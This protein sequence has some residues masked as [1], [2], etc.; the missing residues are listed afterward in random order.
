V[1]TADPARTLL[2]LV[3][4]L[5]IDPDLLLATKQIKFR[6]STAVVHYALDRL[7]EVPGLTQPEQALASVVSLTPALDDLE[8]A[9]DA[10]KYGE[11]SEEPHIEISVPTLR[12]PSLAPSGKHVLSA[13]VRYAPHKLR[14]GATWDGTAS[15]SLA[16]RVTSTI[17]EA[18]P[19][20]VQSVRQR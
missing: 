11:V 5:W 18:I 8:R 9:Y 16:D 4:P 3:D 19:H 20:F 12:W 7:P 17:G 15:A 10:A 1:S 14:D 13:T 2:G 6:G